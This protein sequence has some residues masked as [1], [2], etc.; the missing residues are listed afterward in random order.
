DRD[1]KTVTCKV[2]PAGTPCKTT[3]TTTTSTTSTTSTS[4]GPCVPAPSGDGCCGAEQ[5]MLISS[6]GTLQV[7]NLPPFPFPTGVTTTMNSGPAC[8]ASGASPTCR[9]EV[10]VPAGGFAVPNFDIPALNYC[11][12]VIDRHC[13]SGTGE[14]A[15]QLWDGHAPVGALTNITKNAD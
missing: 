11:S 10:I 15:G 5:I 4:L 9:H 7:D 12:S 8:A 1:T 13:E 3:S 2:H 6:A 14:G